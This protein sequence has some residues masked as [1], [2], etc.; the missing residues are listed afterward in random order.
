MRL[1]GIT[2]RPSQERELVLPSDERR[3]A[4]RRID[5]R[6]Q[7]RPLCRSRCGRQQSY[8]LRRT[9]LQD[10]LVEL[11][12]LDFRLGPEL[13]LKE[14]DA[15]LVLPERRTPPSLAGVEPHQRTMNRLLEWIER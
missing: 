1:P 11:L 10:L 5:L 12:R 15:D 3:L 14:I 2:K 13:T 6:W 9:A 4:T 7:I 8:R